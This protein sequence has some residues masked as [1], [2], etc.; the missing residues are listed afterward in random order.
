MSGVHVPEAVSHDVV[1]T[2]EYLQGLTGISRRTLL[3]W[4]G[5]QRSRHN[6]WRDALA[7]TAAAPASRGLHR[8]EG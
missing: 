6:R 1:V 5:L 8:R 4:V 2:I 7:R 3:G